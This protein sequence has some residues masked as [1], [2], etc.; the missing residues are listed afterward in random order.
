M[1]V[2]V[3]ECLEHKDLRSGLL[4][5]LAITAASRFVYKPCT[6]ICIYIYKNTYTYTHV[7]IYTHTYMPS[8]E[9]HLEGFGWEHD[10]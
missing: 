6:Y 9:T 7:Y 2:Y 8:F 10:Q 5:V 3:D 4:L 1:A